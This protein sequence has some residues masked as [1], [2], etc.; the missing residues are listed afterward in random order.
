VINFSYAYQLP[1][2]AG[3]HWINQK[4][5]VDWILGGWQFNG[6]ATYRSCFVTDIRSSRVA[7]AN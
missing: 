1:F 4:G 2:G 5:P 7:A 6:I 3:K